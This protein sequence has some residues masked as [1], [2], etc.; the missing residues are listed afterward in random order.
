MSWLFGTGTKKNVREIKRHIK[1]LAS[2]QEELVHIV[3]E[4]LSILNIT[5]TEV[6]QYRH[7]IDVLDHTLTSMDAN[8]SKQ[9]EFFKDT[10][11]NFQPG[12]P[13]LHPVATGFSRVKTR[14]G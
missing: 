4:R 1:T 6:K 3:A 14:H 7:M 13:D 2:N 9:Y 12:F 5:R 10:L 11:V 8:I